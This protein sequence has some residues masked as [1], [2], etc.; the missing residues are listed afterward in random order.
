MDTPLFPT[1]ARRWRIQGPPVILD[2]LMILTGTALTALLAQLRVPLLFSP[3]P[4]TGQTFAVLLVGAA[5]GA[6][7]AASSMALYLALGIAGLPIFAGGGHGIEYLTGATGGYLIGFIVAAYLI[8]WLA[9][10][11]LERSFRTSLI[12]F[13]LGNIVIYAFG[14]LW[15]SN[16]LGGIQEAISLGLTP[17]LIGDVIKLVLAGVA[18]PTA[19]RFMRFD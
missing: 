4:I 9:E 1:F 14:V 15:L 19:W 13:L 17:F 12:P 8:G 2:V 6:K 7:R 10:R 5:L 11:G 18:L 3:V 16:Y